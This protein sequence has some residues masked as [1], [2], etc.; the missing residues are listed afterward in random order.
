MKA[1]AL[2]GNYAVLPYLKIESE[3]TDVF[4]SMLSLFFR[5]EKTKSPQCGDFR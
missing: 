5:I 4:S 2:C 3:S 1:A